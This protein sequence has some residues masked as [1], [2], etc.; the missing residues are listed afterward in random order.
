M[1][2]STIFLFNPLFRKVSQI[3]NTIPNLGANIQDFIA[4]QN[5]LTII[6]IPFLRREANLK[7]L[8]LNLHSF[9]QRQYIQYRI[10]VAEQHNS[11]Q[12]FNK[13]RLYNAAFQFIHEMF[14]LTTSSHTDSAFYPKSRSNYEELRTNDRLVRLQAA[15]MVM[16]DVDLIPESDLNV[17]KCQ[18]SPRHLSLSIRRYGKQRAVNEY[19]RSPYDLLI[20]GVLVIKPSVYRRINGFSNEYWNWGAEDDGIYWSLNL[21]V[22][23]LRFKQAFKFINLLICKYDIVK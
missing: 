18:D 20:G 5:K 13:G 8:L 7:D 14:D 1:Q 17:Y 23:G 22:D 11:N 2:H 21:L 9:L 6:I 3:V 15:C 19:E 4:S 12:K 16:H 10:V